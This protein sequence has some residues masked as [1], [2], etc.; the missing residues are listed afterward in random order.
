[1]KRIYLWDTIL[2]KLYELGVTCFEID[3]RYLDRW[4]KQFPEAFPKF[5]LK[6]NYTPY[7]NTEKYR[8]EIWTGKHEI[9]FNPQNYL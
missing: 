5:M 1:M 4:F 6:G 3:I 8:W 2:G 7:F 9:K